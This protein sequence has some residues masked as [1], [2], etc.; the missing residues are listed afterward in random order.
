MSFL[1][2]S[3]LA[4][5]NFLFCCSILSQYHSWSGTGIFQPADVGLQRVIKHQLKQH[6]LEHLVHSHAK[7]LE[8]GVDAKEVKFT[9]SLPVLR[10]QTVRGT[11]KV[12]HFLNEGKGSDIVRKV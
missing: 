2:T 3:L 4:V 9:H 12:W 11:V 7:M 8:S 10:D 1:S 5:S 6:A